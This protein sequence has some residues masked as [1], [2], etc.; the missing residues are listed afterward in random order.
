MKITKVIMLFLLPLAFASKAFALDELVFFAD[1][2]NVSGIS[3]HKQAIA[4]WGFE[5]N[6]YFDELF[7]AAK[8]GDFLS[9]HLGLE[10]P[11]KLPNE[12]VAFNQPEILTLAGGDARVVIFLFPESNF[13]IPSLAT[14]LNDNYTI[15]IGIKNSE[16]F[17]SYTISKEFVLDEEASRIFLDA[18]EEINKLD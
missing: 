6:F 2:D 17:S 15:Y 18:A 5:Q 12:V 9:L 7:K 11:D 10:K 13:T 4:I 8:N 3:L 16:W 14:I 1:E